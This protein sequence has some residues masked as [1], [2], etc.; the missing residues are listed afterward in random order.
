[1]EQKQTEPASLEEA[2]KK[3]DAAKMLAS[4]ALVVAVLTFGYAAFQTETGGTTKQPA[5]PQAAPAGQKVSLAAVKDAFAKSTIRFGNPDAKLTVIEIADPSCPYCQVAGGKNSE[6]NKMAGPRF[7]LVADGG[8]YVAPVPEFK[9]LLDKGEIAFAY[10]YYPGHGT[11]E[12]AMKALYCAHEQGKF[13]EAHDRIM[14]NTGFTL[15][16][17]VKNDTAR[18]GEFVEFLSGAVDTTLLKTCLAGGS[19]DGQL[20]IDKEI[21][22]SLNAQG[23]PGFY[24]NETLYAGA[25]NYTDMEKTIRS[26]GIR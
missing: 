1:M 7:T 13:W 9:N 12:V 16:E 2:I 25:Y 26:A 10:V 4:I 22:V 6:L 5:Q 24:L 3:A 11:G 19:Y 23:T 15:I 8:T 17:S 14:S 21:A 20:A 18:S